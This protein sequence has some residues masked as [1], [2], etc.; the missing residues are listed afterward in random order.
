MNKHILLVMKWLNDHDSVTEQELADN[1]RDAYAAYATGAT[2]ATY[3]ASCCANY[4][5]VA[6]EAYAAA[7]AEKWLERYF[8]LGES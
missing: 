5:A 1:S 2:D 3:A 8:E 6:D 4:A 7:A